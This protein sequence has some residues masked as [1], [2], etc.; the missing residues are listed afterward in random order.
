S[1][2]AHG[3]SSPSANASL[4]GWTASGPA[5]ERWRWATPQ[6][7]RKVV[8]VRI[9][10]RVAAHIGCKLRAL[11]PRLVLAE[12]ALHVHAADGIVHVVLDMPGIGHGGSP[13]ICI[14]S[15]GAAAKAVPPAGIQFC[16]TPSAP[17][18]CLFRRCSMEKKRAR[19][20]VPKT[21]TSDD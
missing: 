18:A 13:S 5:V 10:Q 20:T 4:A 9:G 21:V 2:M 12:P 6:R 16:G 8:L 14:G 7:F 19:K 17:R 3:V 1:G 11:M 15:N